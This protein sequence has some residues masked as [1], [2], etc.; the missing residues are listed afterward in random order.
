[1]HVYSIRQFKYM[2]LF[3]RCNLKIGWVNQWKALDV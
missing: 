1:M 2:P 3:E